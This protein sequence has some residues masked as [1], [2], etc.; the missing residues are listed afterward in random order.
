MASQAK[1][2]NKEANKAVN[3]VDSQVKVAK[4]KANKVAKAK[5]KKVDSQAKV[6]NKVVKVVNKAAQVANKVANSNK[7][8]PQ[9][10]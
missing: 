3:K 7:L 10:P 4:V 6:A 2:V 8:L 1:V 5:V 9:N